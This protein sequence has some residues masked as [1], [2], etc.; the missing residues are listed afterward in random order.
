MDAIPNPSGEQLFG[1]IE[2]LHEHLYTINSVFKL[3]VTIPGSFFPGTVALHLAEFRGAL[4][5]FG[6]P[7]KS[8]ETVAIQLAKSVSLFRNPE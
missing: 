4:K 1:H 6:C 8:R 7:S 3:R 5:L 2:S